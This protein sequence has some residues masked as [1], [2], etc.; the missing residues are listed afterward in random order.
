MKGWGF[1]S[2]AQTRRL[3]SVVSK[4]WRPGYFVSP[5]LSHFLLADQFLFLLKEKATWSPKALPSL[6]LKNLNAPRRALRHLLLGSF[7]AA[8]GTSGAQLGC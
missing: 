6:K 1:L 8:P 4:P 5:F 3:L 7:Q 2:S